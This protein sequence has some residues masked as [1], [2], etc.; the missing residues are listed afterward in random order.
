MNSHTPGHRKF[1]EQP[2]ETQVQARTELPAVGSSAGAEM[3]GTPSAA[4]APADGEPPP[5]PPSLR[6][7]IRAVLASEGVQAQDDDVSSLER[8]VILIMRHSE[9]SGV[10]SAEPMQARTGEAG[11][12]TTSA[13][14]GS[15]PSGRTALSEPGLI[16]VP[17]RFDRAGRGRVVCACAGCEAYRARNAARHRRRRAVATAGRGAAQVSPAS[18]EVPFRVEIAA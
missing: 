13:E 3:G 17:T 16:A 7:S 15:M 2:A 9:A 11:T 18:L 12:A 8:L 14:P 6:A 4:S 1:V 5:S 10:P